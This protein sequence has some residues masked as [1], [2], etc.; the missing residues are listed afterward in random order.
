[1]LNRFIGVLL[2]GLFFIA[3]EQE[4]PTKDYVTLSGTITNANSTEAYLKGPDFERKLPLDA[5]GT[6]KDTMK[7]EEGFYALVHSEHTSFLFLKNSYDISLELDANAPIESLTFAGLGAGTNNYMAD[8]SRVEQVQGLDDFT[9]FFLLDKEQFDQRVSTLQSTMTQL[10]DQGVDLDSTFLA[11]ERQLNNRLI[12]FLQTNY[13][14]QHEILTVLAPGQPSPKFNYPDINGK[15]RSLDE[16]K[17]NY[18]YVDVWAT[19]CGPCKVQ[20]PYLKE[21]EH[22]YKDNKIVFVALSIDTQ[23]NKE[24]WKKMVEQRNLEG[25]QL[26]ADKDWDSEFIKEYRISGIPRF[27]LIDPEGNI[28]SHNAPRPSQPELKDLFD[29][30]NI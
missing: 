20:I 2:L 3:C 15:M 19:W 7:L 12:Q 26:L 23:E 11:R 29:S 28:V 9:K 4:P 16:F 13:A 22:Q 24:R 1:M 6:F 27:I 25:V 21:L 14:D 5:N 18:V 8:K 17:G 30:L 10:I